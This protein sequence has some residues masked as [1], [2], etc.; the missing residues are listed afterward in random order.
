M[1]LQCGSRFTRCV[2]LAA[3]WGVAVLWLP[4]AADSAAAS[5]EQRDAVTQGVARL[6]S[7][8]LEELMAVE[9]ATVTAASRKSEKASDAPAAVIVIDRRDIQA[10]G[11]ATLKDVLRD[12]PGMETIEYYFSEIGTLV[13]VRGIV[14][15]NK[16]VV[17]VNGMRVNP[18]GGENFPFRN[19]FSVRD[20]EKIEVVYG[21]GSTLY[22][23]DAISAVINVITR[24]PT[25][26]E[27]GG[28]GL[29][30]GMNE[31]REVW[32]S[33]GHVFGPDGRDSFSGHIFYH[34][35]NLTGLDQAYP[36]WWRGFLDVS[37]AAQPAGHGRAPARE[38]TGLNVFARVEVGDSSLQAWHRQSERSSAEGFGPG[39]GYLEEAVWGDQSTVVEG[40]NT[41][42]LTAATKLDSAITYNRYEVDPSTRY[43]FPVA[44]PDGGLN[45]FFNDYKYGLG[46]SFSGE[47]TLRV[48]MNPEV[49]FMAG[50]VATLYDIIPKSTVPG[51][52]DTDQ[53]VV[54]QGGSFV[55]TDRNGETRTIQRVVHVRYETYAGYV[56][57]GWQMLPDLKGIL[58]TRV[59]QDTRFDDTPVT[60][61]AALVYSLTEDVTAKYVF[62]RA[63]VAPAPYFGFATYDNG[64][65][66]ADSNPDLKPE[67]ASMHEVNV[68]LCRHDLNLGAS[69]YY[70]EE[71]NLILLADQ[72]AAVNVIDPSVTL[73][74]GSTR[75]LV[76]SANG[77]SSKN[78]GFDL[79][80]RAR[81]GDIS[82]WAS[83]SYVNFEEER[84][85]ATSGPL[86][87]SR[88]NVRL[89]ATWAP[90]A[91]LF[92]TPSLVLRSTPQNVA[93]GTLQDEL[94]DPY[95]INLY[96]LYRATRHVD[97]FITARNVTNHKYALG[98]VTGDAQPQEAFSALAGLS[99]TF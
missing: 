44:A 21:P 93:G 58:G 89:G 96:L 87:I 68:S 78:Y 79:Y 31:E 22:G 54:S 57:G 66:L 86:G 16:I 2:A 41:L 52:A 37:D 18:P 73:P 80:G 76:H 75:M 90:T 48:Q 56:E 9:V 47:E 88:H 70:G 5:A 60:P 28:A 59:T 45:W 42:T 95:E 7:L 65:S 25:E 23:Q 13:P 61:R 12:L 64:Q 8:S 81:L 30:G 34:E 35:S 53:D 17:L 98:G 36:S 85:Q 26:T 77:G 92:I 24:R 51:G 10:R 11:Y 40:R 19:D 1:N 97:T 67:E 91:R 84:D 33:Y 74:D 29:A 71:D 43:V 49:S 39:L 99:V 46:T 15:N 62:T 94:D 83:Y 3:G 38:D 6:K 82:P 14:G 72:G 55:Y 69:A 4:F 63:Y 32:A 50:A 20:A 27:H